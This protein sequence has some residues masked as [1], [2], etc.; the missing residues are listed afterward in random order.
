MP[1]LVQPLF[2]GPIDIVG[3]V[4]G[5]IEALFALLER[6]GYDG[7]GRHPCRRRLVFVGDLTDRG[8]DS[9]AVVRL[10]ESLVESGRAQCVLGNHDLNLL[11]GLR[12]FDNDWFYGQPFHSGGVLVPQ[13][14]ADE[15][16]RK[17]VLDFFASLPIALEGEGLGVVHAH[18]DGAMIDLA[19]KA[20]SSVSL[21]ESHRRRIDDLIA[22]QLMDKVDRELAQQNLN[23]VK[24]LT[25]GPEERAAEPLEEGGKVRYERRVHWWRSYAGEITCVFGHYSQ[26]FSEPRA[27][28]AICVDYG[29]GRRSQVRL[30]R[31][32]IDTPRLAALSLPEMRITFDD[33]ETVPHAGGEIS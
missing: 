6:L 28:R 16:T 20:E 19:R 25:S 12:K 3:D 31:T 11:L 22:T 24:L 9:P 5:E 26:P 7:R 15:P 29:V 10:V 13:V 18:W 30:G 21:Y 27:A 17:R 2:A 33:G 1:S 23:P 4:H 14:L 8:P 32:W